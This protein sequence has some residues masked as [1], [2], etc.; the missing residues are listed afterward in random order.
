METTNTLPQIKKITPLASARIALAESQ[1]ESTVL[2]CALNDVLRGDVKWFGRGEYSLGVTRPASACGGIA[3]VRQCGIV[4]AY[5]F[6]EYSQRELNHIAL[7]VTGEDA[8]HNRELLRRRAAI[9]DAKA[10]IRAAQTARF[11]AK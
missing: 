4:S 1:S 11:D 6:E 9:E 7:I 2:A 3:V 10:Y 5:Y 8:E